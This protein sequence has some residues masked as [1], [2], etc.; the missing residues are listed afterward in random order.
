MIGVV[1]EQ[2]PE[3]G[4]SNPPQY[5]PNGSILQPRTVGQGATAAGR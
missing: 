2:S 4:S 5:T 1:S 3:L